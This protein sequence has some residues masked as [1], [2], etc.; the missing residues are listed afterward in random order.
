MSD[1]ASPPA[2]PRVFPPLE[3]PTRT[4]AAVGLVASLAVVVVTVAAWWPRSEVVEVYRS[5]VKYADG[6]S[7]VAVVRHVRAPITALRLG[8]PV[9]SDADH[10]E[11]VLGS[12][13]SG[14]YGHRIRLD[15]GAGTD[16]ESIR[17]E[18]TPDW[19]TIDLRSGHS[20]TVPA[21]AFLGGR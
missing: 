1:L 8:D 12:D 13:P 18:F 17:V 2:P 3:K 14:N 9:E 6:R 10:Y 19:A 16:V 7:H 15:V 20:L 4:A 21:S 5:D 11:V